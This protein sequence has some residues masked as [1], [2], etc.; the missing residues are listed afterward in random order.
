MRFREAFPNLAESDRAKAH[1]EIQA[2]ALIESAERVRLSGRVQYAVDGNVVEPYV[3][4]GRPLFG[5]F[6][7]ERTPLA[8]FEYWLVI[9]EILA[10]P[11]WA[12][13]KLIASSG[14]YDDALRRMASPQIVRAVPPPLLPSV[15]LHD[16][17]S[18]RLD[19][20]VY[21][22]SGEERIERRALMLDR[23]NEFHFHSRALLAENGARRS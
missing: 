10:S 21:S 11:A 8:I 22:R 7:V 4:R 1:L 15:E 13:T 18:A 5:F 12:T 19:V 20:T 6:D 2:A 16:D 14:E 9:S 17:G 23:A 3:E